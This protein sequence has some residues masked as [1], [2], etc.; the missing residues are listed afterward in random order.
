MIKPF[1]VSILSLFFSSIQIAFINENTEG[2]LEKAGLLIL[3]RDI[4]IKK[5]TVPG[6]TGRMGTL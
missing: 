5:G 1:T 3:T 2:Y 6:K 4:C